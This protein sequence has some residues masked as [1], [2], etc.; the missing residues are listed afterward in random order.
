MKLTSAQAAKLL[1]KLR[2]ERDAL[3][4]Q[5]QRSY[6][7]NATASENIEDVRPDYDYRQVN[8]KLEELDSRIRVIRHALNTFN[9]NTV[10]PETGMTIDT[11][12][13]YIPYLTDKKNKLTAMAARL[14]KERASVRGYDQGIVD[15]VIVNYPLDEV[16]RDLEQVT[17]ELSKA[18]LALDYIN[19]TVELEIPD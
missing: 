18:Q 5:E 4:R 7:F 8:N 15:Y 13:M 19:S 11:L 3:L 14:P 16:K 1:R 2:E 6:V 17:D 9:I 12:L 10:V